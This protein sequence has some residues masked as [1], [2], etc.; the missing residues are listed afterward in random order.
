MSDDAR[1]PVAVEIVRGAP[2][3]EEV[4]ALV[5]VVTE[6]YAQEA[7]AAT[8]PPPHRSRWELSARSLRT[9]LSRERGWTG[10]TG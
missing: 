7:D 10:F 1:E 6:A 9:S 8:A 3:P 4:A 2:T 5:A